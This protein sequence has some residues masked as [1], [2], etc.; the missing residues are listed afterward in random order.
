MV[1]PMAPIAPTPLVVAKSMMPSP[2][3]PVPS[4]VIPTPYPMLQGAMPGAMQPMPF[5][6]SSTGS[7]P[8]LAPMP[9]TGEH[10]GF[11]PSAEDS[12]RNALPVRDVTMNVG[13]RKPRGRGGLVIIIVSTILV[14]GA[15]GFALWYFVLNKPPR[16]K[17]VVKPTTTTQTGS[18]SAAAIAPAGSGSGS[19]AQPMV[20]DGSGSGS[21]DSGSAAM[22]TIAECIV[23]VVTN[24]T[25]VGIFDERGLQ[26]GTS[27]AQVKV[28]CGSTRLILRKETYAETI[29]PVVATTDGTAKLRAALAHASLSVKVSST[30]AGA[31]VSVGGKSKGVTPTTM[32]LPMLESSTIVFTKDGFQT[33]SEKIV[34]RQSNQA[35]HA[36]LKRKGQRLK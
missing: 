1:E 8:H 30:P 11:Y 21:A 7:M 36:Q 6:P 3:A 23:D 32:Q 26:L 14:L 31:T 15:G 2:Q 33:E 27:P 24:P 16:A 5:A 17:P 29:R 12:V 9:P 10:N 25:E 19:A 4:T 22:P 20:A 34:P 18:G 28:P 35:V 13:A